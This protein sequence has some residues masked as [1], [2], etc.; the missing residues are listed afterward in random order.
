MDILCV[1]EKNMQDTNLYNMNWGLGNFSNPN[2]S[3]MP[4]FRP[5]ELFL[6]I[7]S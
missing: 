3:P 7:F 2:I 6:F 1:R 4:K 5:P